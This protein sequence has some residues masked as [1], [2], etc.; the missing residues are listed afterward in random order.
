MRVAQVFNRDEVSYG[1][2]STHPTWLANLVAQGVVNCLKRAIVPPLVEVAPD[3][4]LG[5]KILGQE[6]PLATGPQDVKDGID[7]LSRIGVLRGRPPG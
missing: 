6:P 1:C 3:R 5:R 4:A 2:R 7:D